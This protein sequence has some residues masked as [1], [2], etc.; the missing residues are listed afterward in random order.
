MFSTFFAV[1]CDDNAVFEQTTGIPEATWSSDHKLS[2]DFTID[3]TLTNH[4]FYINVRNSGD[5][6]YSNLYLFVVTEF[7]NGKSAKDTVECILADNTGRWLGTGLGDLVDHQIMFKYQRRFPLMGDYKM[8]L[9]HAM[10]MDP[11]EGISDAGVR[12]EIAEE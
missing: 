8:E 3:D 12:I 7:P 6:P 1:S 9:Q 4:N 10:R 11:L 5:Y 2:F